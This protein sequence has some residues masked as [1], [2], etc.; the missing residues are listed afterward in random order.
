MNHILVDIM[1]ELTNLTSEEAL[2]IED[3][4]PLKTFS[5]GIFLL[6]EGQISK[7][8][9]FV[10]NG[11]IR[12]YELID[13]EE[14]TLDFYTENQSAANFNSLANSIP[15]KQNFVC[16][17]ETTVA[18]INSKKEQKL[19]KMFPRF[20]TFCREGME[21]MM[22]TQQ[23]EFLKFLRLT[24]E[25]RYLNLLNERPNLI[26]RV[27]QYQLASYLGIKPETLSRIR[28]RILKKT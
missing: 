26:N 24:P 8:A 1:S 11:C 14:K 17:E 13:G 2:A 10:V 6:K 4:F 16:I 20:E 19:Y 7:D 28:K 12:N 18:V 25:E 22:G 3:N 21:Q 9:Y 27:P 23:E 15:S 5:K